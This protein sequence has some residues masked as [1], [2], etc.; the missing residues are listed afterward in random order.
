MNKKFTSDSSSGL[1]RKNVRVRK[2]ANENILVKTLL[3]AV[4]FLMSVSAF[5]QPLTVTVNPT[6]VA[7]CNGGTTA[8]TAGVTTAGLTTGNTFACGH[9]SFY[10]YWWYGHSTSHQHYYLYCDCYPYYGWQNRYCYCPRYCKSCACYYIC[11]CIAKRSMCGDRN[12]SQ[13]DW[14]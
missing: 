2:N 5:A 3:L 14:C 6:A 4:T 13:R 11:Q 1:D 9:R 12:N 10:H 8:L 7:I